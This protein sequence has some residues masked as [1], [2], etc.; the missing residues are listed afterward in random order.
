MK[1]G[2]FENKSVVLTDKHHYNNLKKN[3][4]FTAQ[5]PHLIYIRI[6][7]KQYYIDSIMISDAY[8]TR[9]RREINI[10]TFIGHLWGAHGHLRA[11]M[12]HAMAISY[13]FVIFWWSLS[14]TDIMMTSTS[15]T[16]H[17]PPHSLTRPSCM[18]S[19]SYFSFLSPLFSMWFVRTLLLVMLVWVK[20]TYYSTMYQFWIIFSLQSTTF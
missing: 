8:R 18:I 10:W 16:G 11:Y 7:H 14:H 9:G 17:T 1:T 5:L 6:V 13:S 2:S 3:I 4:K 15:S 12:H 19:V 20:D